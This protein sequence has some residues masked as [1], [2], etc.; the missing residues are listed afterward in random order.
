LCTQWTQHSFYCCA[1]T[2]FLS[3]VISTE[4]TSFLIICT[5]FSQNIFKSYSL[6][7]QSL[8]NSR[9]DPRPSRC[10]GPT[11]GHVSRVAVRRH[12]HH[13]PC[14]CGGRRAPGALLASVKM[15]SALEL[16]CNSPRMITLPPSLL[17]VLAGVGGCARHQR[18]SKPSISVCVQGAELGVEKRKAPEAEWLYRGKHSR[19]RETHKM[20]CRC[21]GWPRRPR[22][23][24]R[25]V[26][27][28]PRGGCLTRRRAVAGVQGDGQGRP[29]LCP[30]RRCWA[31]RGDGE[32]RAIRSHASVAARAARSPLH[33]QPALHAA[34]RP[35]TPT[36]PR[37]PAAGQAVPR[38]CEFK[39]DLQSGHN[40]ARLMG[41]G[42]PAQPAPG[43]AKAAAGL[44]RRLS[45]CAPAIPS[46]VS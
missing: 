46:G 42:G 19:R 9:A 11:R 7:I 27:A 3:T 33:A 36:S 25:E 18:A 1:H 22:K 17:V 39:M 28:G 43:G 44:G 40:Y 41:R 10:A 37:G 14:S 34:R 2:Y 23:E 31:E 13:S 15:S 29:P 32:R 21:P 35:G 24:S 30:G 6:F 38:G 20:V 8:S 5:C 12:S 45:G 16:G 26:K 4:N